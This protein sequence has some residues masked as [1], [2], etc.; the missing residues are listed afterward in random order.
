MLDNTTASC[1]P[2]HHEIPHCCRCELQNQSST[3]PV[4]TTCEPGINRSKDGRACITAPGTFPSW[5]I[6]VIVAIIIVILTIITVLSVYFVKRRR[7]HAPSKTR[8]APMMLTPGELDMQIVHKDITEEEEEKEA[9]KLKSA[10][11]H[12]AKLV[13]KNGRYVPEPSGQRTVSLNPTLVS[14]FIFQKNVLFIFQT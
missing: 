9:G 1:R 5:I 10:N 13:K 2:C 8:D 14:C 4:C 3:Q 7:D 11:T 6:V 12:G